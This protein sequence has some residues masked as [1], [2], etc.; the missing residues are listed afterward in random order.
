MDKSKTQI[1]FK[2]KNINDILPKKCYTCFSKKH[3]MYDS[4]IYKDYHII[5]KKC[6][7][8]Y[9]FPRGSSPMRKLLE[10]KQKRKCVIM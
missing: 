3:F 7:S 4:H 10:P 8:V 6:K 1:T 9:T 2:F 5:C